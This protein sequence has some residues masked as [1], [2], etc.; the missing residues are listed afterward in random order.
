MDATLE[1][2]DLVPGL[3]MGMRTDEAA[4][5]ILAEL[6]RLNAEAERLRD[7]NAALAMLGS[8]GGLSRRRFDERLYEARKR[9]A[10]LEAV[11]REY[12]EHQSW[13]CE[14]APH[15]Y[16]VNPPTDDCACG[17]DGTL[18]ALGLF[19]SGDSGGTKGEEA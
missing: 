10:E 7:E 3:H 15:Y 11:I 1:C 14:Y 19:V 18:R 8:D 13:R 4:V 2:C 5:V 12:A 16:L 17:L 9:I 6:K